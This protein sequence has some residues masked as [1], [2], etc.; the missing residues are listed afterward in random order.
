MSE[1]VFTIPGEP[2]PWARARISKS[3]IFFTPPKQKRY[4]NAIKLLAKSSMRGKKPL[5]G[6]LHVKI[7]AVFKTPKSKTKGGWKTSRGDIDNFQK[8]CLD[9][10]NKII[11]D[12]DAQVCDIQASKIYG[13]NPGITIYVKQ[14]DQ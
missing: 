3:G 1:I 4:M 2:I 10:C 11:W 14:L 12:D 6:A 9:A 7:Y 8:I 13:N 5:K